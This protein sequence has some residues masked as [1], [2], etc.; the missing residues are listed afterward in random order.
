MPV[1]CPHLHPQTPN[2]TRCR[3]G[4][5]ALEGPG[6]VLSPDPCHGAGCGPSASLGP[7]GRARMSLSEMKGPA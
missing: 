1:P 7:M 6:W 4:A 2:L 5:G 3:R